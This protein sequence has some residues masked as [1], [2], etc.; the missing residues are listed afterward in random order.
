MTLLTSIEADDPTVEDLSKSGRR[1]AIHCDCCGRFR[2]MNAL[3]FSGD[4][5][6]SALSKTLTCGTCGSS[7]VRAVAVSRNP[8][9]GY[10]PAE[11]S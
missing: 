3:R 9:N 2:Y 8:G 6:V 5:K 4:K 11:F 10:W 1:L 7:D